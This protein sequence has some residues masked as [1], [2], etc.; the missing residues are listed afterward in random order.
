MMLIAQLEEKCEVEA[1]DAR[2]TG[3]LKE[4][5]RALSS[6][7]TMTAPRAMCMLPKN[8]ALLAEIEENQRPAFLTEHRESLD[9]LKAACDN[10][11]E[12]VCKQSMHTF[13]SGFVAIADAIHQDATNEYFDKGS[14]PRIS[15]KVRDLR[16][17]LDDLTI[18]R[19]SD[20]EQIRRFLLVGKHRTALLALMEGFAQVSFMRFW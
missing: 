9:E 12:V 14:L 3:R 13:D 1:R 20:A 17:S 10:G 5:V 19:F 8:R 2:A 4:T 18:S 16:Q 11:V 6:V 15:Q 7:E